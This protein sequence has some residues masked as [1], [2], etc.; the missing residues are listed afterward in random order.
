MSESVPLHMFDILSI[1][2][3]PCIHWR[4][5]IGAVKITTHSFNKVCDSST[6]ADVK[7]NYSGNANAWQEYIGA[8]TL[9]TCMIH[10]PSL[11]VKVKFPIF[12]A[13][14][15]TLFIYHSYLNVIPDEL[16]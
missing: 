12:N 1:F 11:W 7:G 13:H 6:F 3:K 2:H 4:E 16:N 15:L 9:E 8:T 14:S 5:Q 10:S